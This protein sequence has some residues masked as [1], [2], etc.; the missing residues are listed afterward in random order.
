VAVAEALHPHRSA[1]QLIATPRGRSVGHSRVPTAGPGRSDTKL[2]AIAL[3]LVAAIA[4][5]WP[6]GAALAAPPPCTGFTP[7]VET[8]KI[9]DPSV[10]ELSGIAASRA[11][12]GVLWVHND[13]GGAPELEA[14]TEQGAPLGHYPIEGATATDW[15]DIAVGPGPGDDRS[16]SYLYIGDIGD[17]L[18]QRDHVTVYVVAEPAAAP[19]GRGAS[20]PITKQLTITYPAGPAN[21]ESLLVDPL[22]GDLY[23]ITKV[24]SG[25][26]RV[27]EAPA[28][29]VARGGD[30]T[31]RDVGGFQV[32]NLVTAADISPDGSTILVRTYASVL[33]FRR[34]AGATVAAAFTKRPCTAPSVQERQGEA[35]AFSADGSAYFTSSEGPAQPIHRFG[36]DPPLRAATTTTTATTRPATTTTASAPAVPPAPGDDE[37]VSSALVVGLVVV[38]AIVVATVV[39]RR[40]RT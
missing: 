31:M 26:S 1:A 11:H 36:V 15:E 3:A 12:P 37:S 9:S 25:M 4:L 27:L 32:R 10:V 21:A 14:L 16:Q 18:D 13:S 6:P 23:I 17:N 29:A 22:T 19:D 38:G 40:R 35:V 20:L 34:P 2:I 39:I 7:G 24:T 8:G 28:S 30:V 5:L 33:A